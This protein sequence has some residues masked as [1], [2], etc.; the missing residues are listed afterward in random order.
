M[1]TSD[2]C[3]QAVNTRETSS[4][5]KSFCFSSPKDV[6]DMNGIHRLAACGM[7][8]HDISTESLCL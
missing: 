2:W 7:D 3:S 4:G 6:P 1:L 8:G 5:L